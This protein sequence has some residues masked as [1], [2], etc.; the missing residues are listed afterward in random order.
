MMFRENH[1][2]NF[3]EVHETIMW[4]NELKQDPVLVSPCLF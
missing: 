4:A 3:R 1:F 2:E